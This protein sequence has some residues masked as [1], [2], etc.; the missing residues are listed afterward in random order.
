MHVSVQ[1]FTSTTRPRRSP[2]SRGSELS[3]AVAPPSG[4]MCRR[5]ETAISRLSRP[6]RAPRAGEVPGLL[7]GLD[8]PG[9]HQG[10]HGRDRPG[11]AATVDLMDTS[12]SLPALRSPAG[13]A[14]IAATVLASGVGAYDAYVVNV[15]VPAI[16]RHFDASVSAIQWTVTSYLLSVAALLL[17][18]G[19]LADRFGRRRVLVIGLCV[20]FVGSVLC[21]TAASVAALTAARVA[22]GIGAALVVPTSLALLNGGLRFSDRARGIGIW[23]GLTALATTVG[24]YAGGWLVDHGSWRWVFLLNLPLILL[25]LWALRHVPEPAGER[26]PLSLDIL[27][28]LLG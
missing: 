28:A 15:A 27:G 17:L 1:K 5:S 14:L 4:G 26:R 6:R 19:A 16:G 12:R 18:V 23:A 8:G 9:G 24:P 10:D 20:M 21:A 3:H 2:R 25:A 13:I 11:P 22:Q 7:P